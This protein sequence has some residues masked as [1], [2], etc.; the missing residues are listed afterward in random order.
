MVD[1][2][3]VSI[4]FA[5]LSIGVAAIYYALTLRNT[6]KNQELQ[7]E[8]RQAQLFMEVYK[9]FSSPS[10][11]L[12]FQ[13]IRNNIVRDIDKYREE[14]GDLQRTDPERYAGWIS[15]GTWFEGLGTLLKHGL[16]D[17]NM[18]YDMMGGVVFRYWNARRIVIE[19]MQKIDPHY[20]E[21]IAYLQGEMARIAKIKNPE[22]DIHA[23]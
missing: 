3:T 22:R 12:R 14:F 10:F 11:L 1:A 18:V 8:T 20:G 5:G 23:L 19:E 21:Y 15:L 7:L 9:E 2:Q 17:P 16:I 4:I 13:D 6:R